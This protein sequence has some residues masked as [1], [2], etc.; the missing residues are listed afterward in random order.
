MV[1]RKKLSILLPI[2]NESPYIDQCIL[3]I[4]QSQSLDFELII[5][6]NYSDDDTWARVQSYS[7]NRIIAIQ[8]LQQLSLVENWW[9]AFF[10]AKGDFIY[11]LGGDD[12]LVDGVL[13]R[14]IERLDKNIVTAPVVYFND[15]DGQPIATYSKPEQL[16]KIIFKD[17][18]FLRNCLSTYNIDELVLSFFPRHLIEMCRS[19][20][21]VS[22]E[23]MPWW[24][25]ITSFYAWPHEYFAD[26]VFFKRYNKIHLSG[27]SSENPA[28]ELKIFYFN[29]SWG[30]LYNS[31]KVCYLLKTMR[32]LLSLLFCNR[33][34]SEIGGG[35]LGSARKS[36]SY[37]FG[38]PLL[39]L[40]IS[41]LLTL[42][43]A[44]KWTL[45]TWRTN[46]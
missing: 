3:S 4:L 11:Y 23:R 27:S 45:R 38:G 13:D 2:R 40:L 16:K 5:S 1:T 44:F 9:Y 25:I 6:D 7:D 42:V 39:M 14:V 12:Y 29:R 21:L 18:H 43:S 20:W 15:Q 31:F 35:F 26:V 17:D 19:L 37:W 8:P 33:Y 46:S 34:H 24:I 32:P 30:S 22:W 41:P 28:G 10:Q 36:K